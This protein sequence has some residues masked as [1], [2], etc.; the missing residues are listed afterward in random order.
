ME[1]NK[2]ATE[3][4]ILERALSRDYIREED[5]QKL[6]T[7]TPQKRRISP[8]NDILGIK[9]Q[10]LVIVLGMFIVFVICYLM[11]LYHQE[12]ETWWS[13]ARPWLKFWQREK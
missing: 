8:S 3:E 4:E 12:I 9:G 11:D 10:F 7:I 13:E 2:A 1:K 6:R 5:R